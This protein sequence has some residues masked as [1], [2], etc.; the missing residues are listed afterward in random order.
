VALYFR[1]T[2]TAGAYHADRYSAWL[3]DAA[4]AGIKVVRPALSPGNVLITGRAAG[5]QGG[6]ANVEPGTTA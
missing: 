4:F 6:T 2:S 1:L 5:R 3:R